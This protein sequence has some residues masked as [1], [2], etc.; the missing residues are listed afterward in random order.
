MEFSIE[1]SGERRAG[2]LFEQFPE[3]ARAA[4]KERMTA[5]ADQLY[6]RVIAA[7]PQRTGKLRS[8]TARFVDDRPEFVRARVRVVVPKGD[9]AAGGKAAALEYGAHASVK[10]KSHSAQ[11]NHLWALFVAP[12]EVMVAAHERRV[13]IAERRFLRGSI[14]SLRGQVIAELRAALDEAAAQG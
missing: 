12:R 10:V 6:A 13:N 5:I 7:E 11:L 2:L 3:R 4:L 8:Q 9:K 14:G 1:L